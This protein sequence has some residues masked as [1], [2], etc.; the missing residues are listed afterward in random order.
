M[1]ITDANG[2]VGSWTNLLNPETGKTRAQ[3]ASIEC[4]WT[5]DLEGLERG[6]SVEYYLKAQDTSPATTGV[7]VA[8]TST[9]SFEVG[10]PNK[11][12]I[13]EWHDMSYTHPLALVLSKQ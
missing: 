4:A 5:Y 8:N 1:R 3:C 11:M 10:D 13:I 6:S 12:F 7:N 2:T 9:Y